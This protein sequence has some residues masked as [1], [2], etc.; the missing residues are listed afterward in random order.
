MA[1]LLYLKVTN[2]FLCLHIILNL[3]IGLAAIPACILYFGD[4]VIKTKDAEIDNILISV[5][6]FFQ[7]FLQLIQFIVIGVRSPLSKYFFKF[8]ILKEFLK[9]IKQAHL[10]WIAL[11]IIFN[12][13]IC[14]GFLIYLV[15]NYSRQK[16]KAFVDFT[17]YFLHE[18][19]YP[20]FQLIVIQ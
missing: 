19:N 11:F 14:I 8:C 3:I 4:Y 16:L 20:V 7:I 6:M 10:C 5:Y 9:K 17:D 2:G 15:N 13:L 1:Q 18:T 12:H